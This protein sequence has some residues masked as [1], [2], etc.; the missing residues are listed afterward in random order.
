MTEKIPEKIQKI[1]FRIKT[2]DKWRSAS[3]NTVKLY[4][5]DHVWEL[6][7]PFCDDFEKGKSDTFELEVP[8]GMDST[9]FHYLCLKKEGDIIGDRWCLHAVQ[10]KINDKVV[11]QNDEIEAW[12]EGGKTSWCAPDFNYGQD[13]PVSP[14]FD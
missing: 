6:D 14:D 7:H 1:E 5:G 13:I 9:W 4:V 8:T 12:F 10:L 11:Y 2:C 3:D